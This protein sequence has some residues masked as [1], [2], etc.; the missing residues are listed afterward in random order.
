[1]NK[2]ELIALLHEHIYCDYSGDMFGIEEVADIILAKQ[3]AMTETLEDIS[4]WGEQN[5]GHWCRAIAKR[6]LTSSEKCIIVNE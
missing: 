4:S 3:K 6:V 5:G 1:M 2:K